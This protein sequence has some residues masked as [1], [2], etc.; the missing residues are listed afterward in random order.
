MS[1][2]EEYSDL[3]GTSAS[4]GATGEKTSPEDEFFHSIYIA[5]KS[6]KNE[7]GADEK[8][9]KLQVRGVS[10][11]HEELYMII[12]HTKDVKVKER[13]VKGR[14]QLECFSYKDGEPPW[15]GTTKLPDGSD[16]ICPLTSSERAMNDFC[17]PCREQIIIAGI[18]CKENGSPILT[19]DKKPVFVFLRGKGMRYSPVSKYL[20]DMYNE[21]LPPLFKPVTEQSQS[22]EKKVVNNKRFVTNITIGEEESNYGNNVKVFVLE[23]GNQ[24][25]D[26]TVLKI[27]KLSKET[28]EQFKQK[29]DWSKRKKTSGY[30]AAGIL[31]TEDEPGQDVDK[32]KNETAGD[33]QKTFSFDDIEF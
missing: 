19:E 6:R 7:S 21:E 25:P 17:N 11:N 5:G 23:K 32:V 1:S 24:I 10:Y 31:S 4:V 3:E 2:F 18:F 13:E 14:S 29:F 12:T 9:G 16:R 27:L 22:F 20:S 15:K 28:V 33:D 26:E 8:S 30:E